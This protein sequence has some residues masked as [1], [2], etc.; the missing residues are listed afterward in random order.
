MTERRPSAQSSKR[1]KVRETAELKALKREA[2]RLD[3][4]FAEDPR[5]AIAAARALASASAPEDHGP[6]MVAAG[7]LVD[8]GQELNDA[9]AIDEGV[10]YFRQV[11]AVVP[12]SSQL[13]YNL[14]N[15]ISAQVNLRTD[16]PWSSARCA[17]RREARSL[18]LRSVAL[19]RSPKDQSKAH[20][21][22]ANLLRGS[23][24]MLEAYD[25][26][27]AALQGEPKNGVASSGVARLLLEIVTQG[28]GPPRI[29]NPG[30]PISS[31][32]RRLEGRD[33]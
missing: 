5:A 17:A 21:N 3:L 27:V 18:Y 9:A 28:L 23:Y 7:I 15:G 19:G 31:S 12:A 26:Y 2:A 20:T 16:P 33:C 32:C 25:A 4:L 24:R 1:R 13:D 14:A 11:H 30:R 6:K 8:A 10:A 29:D 22:H